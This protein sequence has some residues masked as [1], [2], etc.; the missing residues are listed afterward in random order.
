MKV[1]EFI[2]THSYFSTVV[3]QF[4]PRMRHITLKGSF[5][6]QEG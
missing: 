4:P 1:M 2:A 6:K 3:L 5:P